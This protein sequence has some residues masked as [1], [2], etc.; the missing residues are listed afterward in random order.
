MAEFIVVGAGLAGL[1]CALA[2][3]RSGF[4]VAL[5]E[6]EGPASYRSVRSGVPQRH[7]GHSFHAPTVAFLR[8]WA[9]DVLER[10]QTAGATLFSAYQLIPEGA[11]TEGDLE[12]LALHC[13]RAQL[14]DALAEAVRAEPRVRMHYGERA[15]RLCAAGGRVIGVQTRSGCQHGAAVV[16]ASGRSTPLA[17]LLGEHGVA[18]TSHHVDVDSL[19]LTCRFRAGADDLP[20]GDWFFG[21]FGRHRSVRWSV[22][23]EAARTFAVTLTF[24]RSAHRQVQPLRDAERWLEAA[25]HIPELT[26]W[27]RDTS[28]EPVTGVRPMGAARNAVHTFEPLEGLFVVGDA[29][30]QTNPSHGWGASIALSASDALARALAVAP[31][32][33]SAALAFQR[34]AWPLLISN[35]V[36]SAAEDAL[37]PLFDGWPHPDEVKRCR[38][39]YFE[40]ALRPDAD[41]DVVRAVLRRIHLA[42]PAT[43]LVG[44]PDVLPDPD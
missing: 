37:H 4:T 26:T 3:S 42:D 2:L 18:V 5:L 22:L 43:A 27:I 13:A 19:W 32:P 17:R 9:P 40:A 11:R 31:D 16:L 36:A 41:P 10:L 24:P 12:L 25:L 30:G 6:R 21:P 34:A 15:V 33:A 20:A 28:G 38:S 7:S 8:R 35:Y 1:S 23:P 29:L 39:Q 14:E 44:L